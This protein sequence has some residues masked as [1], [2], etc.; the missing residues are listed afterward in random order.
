[1]QG[2]SQEDKAL[3]AHLLRRAG[4]GSTVSDVDRL[5]Q[6]GYEAAVEE[7]LFPDLRPQLDED[8]IRRYHVDQNSLMLIESSQAYWLYK[9]INTQR[10][11]EEKL[12]LFW[13][14][15]FATAY[16][17]LNHAKA[18]ANQIELFRRIGLS[19]IRTLLVSIS[20]DPAMLFWLD[21]KDNTKSQP[22][23]N[24]GRELLE[25]FSMGIGTYEEQDVRNCARAFTGWTI[26]NA[27]YMSIRAARDSVWPYGRLD[28][29]FCYRPEAH[30]DSTKT[31]LGRTGRFNGDDIIDIICEQ[32]AT[33]SFICTKL[34]QFFV[35]DTLRQEAI[36]TLINV[37]TESHG[38]I[39]EV[40]RFL[41]NSDD[42]KAQSNRRSK[43][44]SPVELLTQTCRIAGS[45]AFPDWTIVQ[46]AMDVNFMGQEILNPP[47]VEGWHTGR[48]WIDTGTL[49]ER[50]NGAANEISD[51]NQP[52]VR[53]IINKVKEHGPIL[54]AATLVDVSLE[55]MSMYDFSDA[56]RHQLI[57]YA[58]RWGDISFDRFDSV[59]CAEQRVGEILQMIVASRDYQMG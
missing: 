2:Y 36:R 52:G 46:V 51:P 38:D 22:N 27:E 58:S 56:T 54:S 9:L 11:L 55:A 8:L 57:S 34:Y 26:N 7:L 41:F 28:W 53:A 20:R 1:M 30:D 4:M 43:V 32:E 15:L 5:V 29:Q 3:I 17:K 42:F 16:G 14:G 59:Q 18:V 10:P 48:E 12:A 24:Y 6:L 50:L 25:L 44:L 13:H 19:N 39:R 23:E 31:F 40:L 35:S 37:F 21:N 33:A 45:H 47:T 49:V